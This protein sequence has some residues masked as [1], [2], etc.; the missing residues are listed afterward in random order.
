MASFE[1]TAVASAMN[2]AY[3][4]GDFNK[5]SNLMSDFIRVR[6]YEG[7]VLNQILGERIVTTNDLIPNIE[8]DSFYVLEQLEM[9]SENAVVATFA[10]RPAERTV[11]AQRYKVPFGIHTTPIA[12][13]NTN[14][15]LVFGYDL[16][17]QAQEQDVMELGMLRD[18]RFLG[19]LNLCLEVSG[20]PTARLENE[21]TA[22]KVAPSKDFLR[23]ITDILEY[24]TAKGIPTK[25]RL[26]AKKYIFG[27][28]T[29]KDFAVLNKDVL[30]DMVGEVLVNGI[31]F[32]TLLG[33]PFLTSIKQWFFTESDA[34]SFITVAVSGDGVNPK[35][36]L[37]G[38]EHTL[39]G[40]FADT[41]AVTAAFVE[42]V[43]SISGYEAKVTGTGTGGSRVRVIRRAVTDQVSRIYS[44]PE[45]VISAVSK[46]AFTEVKN[47]ANVYD[48][49]WA[50]PDPEFLGRVITLQ[51]H[52]GMS[53]EVWKTHGVDQVN[54]VT[55]ERFAAGIGNPAGVAKGLL[56]RSRFLDPLDA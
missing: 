9:R 25:D 44:A 30:G 1:K 7:C 56:Q 24:G 55:K 26:L 52:E 18:W 34:V 10:D 5:I 42:K 31:T 53:S 20:K 3:K 54:R 17:G 14:N 13:L 32:T 2:S 4:N 41:A 37:N 22:D 16:L 51:G 11:Y 6:V 21:A 23:E 43:N 8:D 33:L 36:S 46:I 29:I 38:V 40:T 48:V 27:D 45:N 49:G 50:F 28:R 12:T 47:G 39:Q 15:Q 35:F 19:M